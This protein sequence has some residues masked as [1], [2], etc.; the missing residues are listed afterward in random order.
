MR[1]TALASSVE[2]ACDRWGDRSAITYRHHTLSYQDVWTAVGA[3]AGAYAA[4][5]VE[6]GERIVCQLPTR[7]E[8]LVAANAAWARRAIHMGADKDLT[9]TEL[10]SLVARTD[11][12][13]VIVQPPPD[14][15][16][17]LAYGRA[18]R[19]ARPHTVTI[20]HDTPLQKGHPTLAELLSASAQPLGRAE[21]P[22]PEA[23]HTDASDTA[24][25]FLTSGT[26]GTSKAVM[27]TLS[28]LWAKMQFFADAFR[29]G[30]DDVH[31]MYLPLSHAFGLKLSLT[32]LCSGGRL[33]MLDRFSPQEALRLA[34]DEQASILPGTP[35]HFAMLLDAVDRRSHDLSSL[36]WAVTAAA[37]LPRPLLDRLYYQLGVEVFHVYGCSEGFLTATTDRQQL[38][39]GSVGKNA[40]RGPDGTPP[41][42]TV[43][44]ADPDTHGPVGR[45]EIGEIAYG[46][47][48][49]VR[50]WQECSAA[51]DG[52]YRTGDLGFIDADG[53]LFV[54]GRSKD[55]V[56][57][58]GLKVVPGEVEG[59]LFAH[60]AVAD[61][62]VVPAPDPVLGE[63]ICACV[64][65][66]SEQPAPQL[67][68]LRSF[69]APTVARHKLPD[70][71]C[72]LRA[73]PRTR[74]GKLDR[75]A[76]VHLVAEGAAPRER[77]RPPCREG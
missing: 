12:A 37:P 54:R 55:V 65:A 34:T 53:C 26:T 41:D 33:V 66:S 5:G 43:T 49:P 64:V 25:L 67:R 17:P 36:R 6:P 27:E 28:A 32:A 24:L 44:V 14:T 40:F 45:G 75:R 16:D 20:G 29:P 50:Y 9:P 23:S 35:A 58:G 19:E 71:L 10:A 39:R 59:P 18:V 2:A 52:W 73:L 51:T 77:L 74:T 70:E 60:P 15:T 30:P 57:R 22:A 8:H 61:C 46:A 7:P 21:T 3:L 31:V 38:L 63:A 69:L 1:A 62:A 4:L 13:A 47:R 72:V 76:L 42:G 56:N 11:A 68:E 48:S